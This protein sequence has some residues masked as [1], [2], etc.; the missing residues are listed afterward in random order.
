[1]CALGNGLGGL[2]GPEEAGREQTTALAS[3]DSG[4]SL[5]W[6]ID[7]RVLPTTEVEE[8]P[9][10]LLATQIEG[11]GAEADWGPA[12]FVLVSDEPGTV[13]AGIELVRSG[14]SP[15]ACDSVGVLMGRR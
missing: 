2:D 6:R 9:V 1:M 8:E 13:D 4:S 12:S 14:G 3:N 7:P 15:V 5:E 11:E 10:P